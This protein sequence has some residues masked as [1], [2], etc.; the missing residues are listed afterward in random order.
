MTTVRPNRESIE[1]QNG[2]EAF[3]NTLDVAFFGSIET[4]EMK[5]KARSA[6]HRRLIESRMS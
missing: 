1:S 5:M 2:I 3:S 4:P 6:K